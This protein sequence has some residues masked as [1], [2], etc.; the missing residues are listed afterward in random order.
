M[1]F[2]LSDNQERIILGKKLFP[3]YHDRTVDLLNIWFFK[4]YFS[5][6]MKLE[7]DSLWTILYLSSKRELF[8]KIPFY[9]S[10]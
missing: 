2:L 4:I 10:Y 8:N 3:L 9:N 5:V 1:S 6:F 7:S